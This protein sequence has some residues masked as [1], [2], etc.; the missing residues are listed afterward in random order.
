MVIILEDQFLFSFRFLCH[1]LLIGFEMKI[2]DIIRRGEIKFPYWL[3]QIFWSCEKNEVHLMS[4]NSL[5]AKPYLPPLWCLGHSC[6]LP[7][8]PDHV[9]EVMFLFFYSSDN[10]AHTQEFLFKLISY[11]CWMQC[12]MHCKMIT[13]NWDFGNAPGYIIQTSLTC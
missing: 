6:L 13:C 8:N 2:R 9:H 5:Q 4:Q 1:F 12:W 7:I 11:S 10:A 3:Q